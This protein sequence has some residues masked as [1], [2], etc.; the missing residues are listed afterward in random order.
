MKKKNLKN[1]M[2]MK[3][4]IAFATSLVLLV[5]L[6][7]GF[8]AFSRGDVRIASFFGSN[9]SSSLE[10]SDQESE[11]PADDLAG[12]LEYE[13]NMI[14]NP[15]TGRISNG[16]FDAERAQANQIVKLQ[17]NRPDFA[18]AS[19][20]FIGPNNLGG[21]TRSVVYD[22]RY[23]GGANQTILACGVSNGV[24]KSNDNGATWVRKSQTGDHF[25]C[26]SL[27]Q[28]TRAGFQDTW[29]YGV[30][31]GIGNT[32]SAVGATY[33]GNGVYKSTDNGETW[34]RLPNSNTSALESFDDAADLITRVAV[35]P[36][37]GNVFMACLA[38]IRRSTDGG[39]NW[40]DVLAGTLANTTQSTDVV[41]TSTGVIYAALSG[42]AGNGQAG[43]SQDGVHR[44]TDGGATFIKIAGTGSPTNPPGW[45]NTNLGRIVLA[46]APSNE[47][48]VY[49]IYDNQTKS[50]CAGTPAPEAD[51]YYWNNQSLVWTN[52]STTL[53][54]EPGCT[55]GNDP[56]AHQGGYDLTVAVKPD[57]ANT[58][59][60]GGTNSYR[61][62]T[63]GQSWTRI[64]GYAS[65]SG[66]AQYPN[67]HS[68]IQTFAFQPGTPTT[69]LS[70]DDGGVQ[71][72][73][74]DLA[75]AVV[76]TQTNSGFRTYQ[77]YYVANDPRPA[78]NKVIGGAQD[79]GT[80]RNVGGTGSNF[81][82]IFSGDG[83]SVGLSDPAASGS[84][85]YE[86]VGV[87][88]GVILRRDAASGSGAGDDIQ[89]TGATGGLFVTLFKLDPDNTQTLYYA[90]NNNLY[91][92]TSASTVT[93]GTWT[94]MTGIGTAATGGNISAIGLTRG[95]Y[96]AATSSLFVGT[97]NGKLFRLDNPTNAPLAAPVN[98]TGANFPA[99]AY[100]S[101]VAVSP[102]NDGSAIVTFSNYGVASVFYTNNVN[103][104]APTWTNVE[105]NIALSSF[106]SSSILNIN[107]QLEYYVGTSTGLYRITGLP[108]NTTWTKE[109]PDGIG[110][111]VVSSLD[112]RVS[113]NKL[114]VGTHG[115]GI[116]S[117]FSPT[118]AGVSISG[119]VVSLNGRG[120]SGA[121]V[122]M[123]AQN[124]EVRAVRTNPFGY[125]NLNEAA[126][127]QTY[128]FAVKAKGYQFAAQSVSLTENL[129][130]LNFTAQR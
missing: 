112:L 47:N 10:D 125:Y 81:E 28:D 99:G 35:D 21:R 7:V 38:T 75:S 120:I 76:W 54:D 1:N 19:Y 124:G 122:T 117:A 105:G 4:K 36:T 3:R 49:A 71:R 78:N 39:A 107:G 67:S 62:N 32:A 43:V 123:T 110:N 57:D 44:S 116:W 77:Y 56:F 103:A 13:F 94:Q 66:Y 34:N 129:N 114:L 23:N 113:D 55:D 72:T 14:K 30:G 96:N 69:M 22:V 12:A 130:G 127:G 111:S 95:A 9:S 104:A 26:T 11:N 119:S 82:S 74:D 84:V 80:T 83:V 87:Q 31:E 50:S 59:F 101:S 79:N 41:I 93:S 45:K 42:N 8:A 20:S 2:N 118:A 5:G 88:N 86:Y 126:A 85:Q 40:T 97:S 89:P 58:V 60:I 98:I 37:N 17:S 63:A 15:K 68:D 108:A 70:G 128:V 91:Q 90:S 33:S 53:P 65:P 106:R 6:V 27:A 46:I 16:T 48:R 73:T 18:P 24:Y 52:R 64:G 61:S 121:V 102:T 25:S 100:V 92:T 115:Y 29:Y 109:S 51:F